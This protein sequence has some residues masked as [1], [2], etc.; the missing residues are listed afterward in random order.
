MNFDLTQEQTHIVDAIN[1]LCEPFDADY[2]LRKDR[3]GSFPLDFHGALA[4][5][6]WLG[7]AMP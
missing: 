6:G 3:E 5:S 1:R 2:W 4:S 7:I